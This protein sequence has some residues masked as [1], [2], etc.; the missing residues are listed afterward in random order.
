MNATPYLHLCWKEYRSVRAFWIS[1]VILT[2]V[3]QVLLLFASWNPIELTKM[4]YVLALGFPALFA[5][6]SAGV[7]FAGE[8]EEGTFDFLRAA[9][10]RAGQLFASKLTVIGLAT[11]AM[12][13]VLCGSALLVARGELPSSGILLD[14][15]ALWIVAGLEAIA[16]G[17]LFSLL[18]DRPLF[19]V[20]L[21]IAAGSMIVNVMAWIVAPAPN[22]ALALGDY[23]RVLPGRLLVTLAV[24]AA[25]IYLGLHWLQGGL[26]R[27]SKSS[28]T[29]PSDA[30]KLTATAEL[31]PPI[32]AEWKRQYPERAPILVRLFWQ[33]WRQSKWLMLLMAVLQIGVSAV[34]CYS[35][36]GKELVG[37]HPW[38]NFNYQNAVLV[39]L[40][41]FSA[42]MGSFVFLG[43]Q[44]RRN[45]RFFVEHNVPSR[46][47][48][49]TRQVPWIFTALVSTLVVCCVWL[50]AESNV[51]HL[52]QMVLLA[53]GQQRYQDYSGFLYL[54][55]LPYALSIAAVSFA[56]GQ[57]VSMFVRSGVLAGFFGLLLCS[58]LC[59]WV[60]LMSVLHIGWWWSVALIPL[61]LLWATW[62]RAPDWIS[63]NIT[64]RAR[65][66]AGTV[67]MVPAL[68]LCIAVP[69]YRVQSIPVVQPGFNPAEY[70]AGITP[71]ALETA[72]LYQRAGRE[73]VQK[74]SRDDADVSEEELDKYDRKLTDA[75][76]AWLQANQKSLELL[77][78]A[79]RR[80]TC[81]MNNPE[82]MEHSERIFGVY[83]FFP[84]LIASGR[85]LEAEGKLDEAL[86]HYA[87][88][89]R[90]VSHW[91]AFEPTYTPQR[92]WTARGA[93]QIMYELPFWAAQ[94]GQ[95]PERIGKAI[96]MLKAADSG[97]LHVSDGIKSDY[98]LQQRAAHGDESA[99]NISYR[100]S[101]E[102][103][104]GRILR[105]KFMP[106]EQA[107]QLRMINLIAN[108]SLEVLDKVQSLIQ[109]HGNVVA[110]LP[111]RNL[112]YANRENEW[113]NQREEG[114]NVSWILVDYEAGRRGTMLQLAL[115][116]YRLQHDRLP[117]SLNDLVGPYFDKLP[118]DPYSG[119]E[120]VYFLEGIPAPPTPFE[121]KELKEY[122]SGN[123]WEP[124]GQQHV[125]VVPGVPCVWCTSP[126][127]LTYNWSDE[128]RT[129]ANDSNVKP[130]KIVPYYTDRNDKRILSPYTAWPMGFWFPIPEPQA[131]AK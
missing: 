109:N 33:H 123:A 114:Y 122:G 31:S 92:D 95:T 70:L 1:T 125:P 124:A 76:R 98:I 39:P 103:I 105:S 12:Y 128:K 120:F 25:D 20:I 91:T 71:E 75:D 67:V 104:F 8:Q 32:A 50:K 100:N 83:D 106:G 69:I 86:E 73:Y 40:A 5:V 41:V 61:L 7:A 17:T 119:N 80:P 108:E 110:D 68:A 30:A 55:P 79:S 64:W 56:A 29:R 113:Y 42:L 9:P 60:Y 24:F 52:W 15:I 37:A 77:L 10:I 129:I 107:Y 38:G 19:A 45:F 54:P 13:V 11:L 97:I 48:W 14:L 87:A 116:A 49:F 111:S 94:P 65:L 28:T 126:Y 88:A 44:E 101:Y 89:L 34:V 51:G 46:Y 53:M 57:W 23:S 130:E 35:N 81:A 47:V 22:H 58:V 62:L 93:A 90:M 27:K 43:D 131:E 72:E 26:R 127:M 112:Y 84:L 85:Q 36:T 118:T 99:F 115:E 2:A 3:L 121:A 63:E 66:Q 4:T 21:A 59:Y 18:M 6:G 96:E 74:R 117:T 102:G 78:D 16:W 82:T